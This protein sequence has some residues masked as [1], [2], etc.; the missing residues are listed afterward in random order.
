[1]FT[2]I[3]LLLKKC[4]FKSIIFYEK[5]LL[6]QNI[7]SAN[8]KQNNFIKNRTYVL[9]LNTDPLNNDFSI[10]K[11]HINSRPSLAISKNFYFKRYYYMS[12]HLKALY[13]S[14][15]HVRINSRNKLI[16]TLKT[17]PNKSLY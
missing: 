15:N 5:I 11:I 12:N 13:E 3:E 1:M 8:I 4:I 9:L 17:I 7:C 16:K 6:K 2:N 14:Q 10:L